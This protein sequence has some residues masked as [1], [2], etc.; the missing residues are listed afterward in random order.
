MPLQEVLRLPRRRLVCESSNRSL[1]LQNAG[2]FSN[3][4]FI[5]FNDALVHMQ[6]NKKTLARTQQCSRTH[7]FHFTFSFS[8][9]WYD[10]HVLS[11][12]FLFFFFTFLFFTTL[13]FSITQGT[14]PSQSFV[15][16]PAPCLLAGL[17]AALECSVLPSVWCFGSL[18][19]HRPVDL[20]AAVFLTALQPASRCFI[21][22]RCCSHSD[23]NAMGRRRG[24]LEAPISWQ[25]F[26]P[27]YDGADLHYKLT[28]YCVALTRKQH[29]NP[30]F[31][32]LLTK[33]HV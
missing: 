28:Q 2:R 11:L 8:S 13:Y 32:N 20:N 5:L 7:F 10:Y 12:I 19:V 14:I 21:S 4:W 15:S 16:I 6:V 33:T 27:G 3:H 30:P 1:T 25:F 26:T 22:V 23:R 31:C 18:R 29:V 17:Q 24:S 9:S